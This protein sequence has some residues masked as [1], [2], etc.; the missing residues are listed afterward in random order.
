M[1]F[2][3][4]TGRVCQIFSGVPSQVEGGVY[5]R[6]SPKH[7]FLGPKP[8]EN[9]ENGKQNDHTVGMKKSS[10]LGKFSKKGTGGG[11]C[12]KGNFWE[13]VHPH[14]SRMCFGF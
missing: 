6:T 13:P 11:G 9:D 10:V 7:S 12:T 14:W 1:A 5:I 8:I 4:V 2:L 3:R